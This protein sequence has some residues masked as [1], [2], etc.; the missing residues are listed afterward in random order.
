MLKALNMDISF[1]N[2]EG[3]HLYY[4]KNNKIVEVLDLVGG[5]GAN[6]LGHNHPEVR[7]TLIDFISQNKPALNSQG[8]LQNAAGI[9]PEN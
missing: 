2:A 6:L 4:E 1:C 9:W 7:K 3:D 8:S 5:Y